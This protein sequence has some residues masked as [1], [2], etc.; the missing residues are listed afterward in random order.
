[1]KIRLL[2]LIPLLAATLAN[3][4]QPALP[5]AVAVAPPQGEWE[6][7]M[8]PYG[9]LAGI[10]GT[11]TAKGY[12]AES[13]MPF[14]DVITNLDMVAMLNI[15]AR[16]GRWGGWVDGIYMK[17][18]TE[19]DTPGPLLDSLEMGLE[20]VLVEGALFYRVWEGERGFLDVYGG[21]RYTR[22]GVDLRLDVND[23][24][25][26]DV[27]EELS[28]EVIDSI[29]ASVKGKSAPALS[30]AGAKIAAKAQEELADVLAEKAEVVRGKVDH[31]RQIAAAHPRLV[32][33]I[34][35]SDQL[36]AAIRAAAETKATEELVALEAKAAEAQAVAGAV[37]QQV[38]RVKAQARKAV[39]RAEKALAKEIEKTLQQ[40]LPEEISQTADW[41]DP[42]VG[43]RGL[44]HFT[45]RFYA[46]AKADVGGFGVGSELTWQAYAGLGWRFNKHVSTEI[47]YRH[48]DVDYD[49]GNGAA[50]DLALSGAQVAL[51]IRF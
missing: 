6:F 50:Y 5:P 42:F 29:V 1:M 34:R 14:E 8:T 24:A 46:V 28:A 41:V 39:Q 11:A 44:Y 35:H 23:A 12:S 4:G 33:L 3:A 45:D 16:K 47:G 49:G 38:A 22:M 31:L 19:A 18:S 32:K 10:D 15:E 43:L 36:R 26:R 30:R 17:L 9:W 48:M 27:S 13:S 40:A 37:R 7:T 25:V 20:S 21:A 51:C 2:A